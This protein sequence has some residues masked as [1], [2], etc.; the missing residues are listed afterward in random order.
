MTE[1]RPATEAPIVKQQEIALA[2]RPDE[3][4]T[5]ERIIDK[6][7]ELN[8]SGEELGKL[9][10]VY[11]RLQDKLAEK[12][13]NEA[14]A[15]FQAECP[16]IPKSQLQEFATRK[17]GKFKSAYARLDDIDEVV[18]PVLTK[19][20]F[21]RSFGKPTTD[22]QGC[23]SLSATLWHKDGASHTEW[24][25]P[26]PIESGLDLSPQIKVCIALG[27]CRRL[28]FVAACGIRMA[29]VDE[30]VG[31]P[32][33][34][35]TDAQ[36]KELDGIFNQFADPETERASFQRWLKIDTVWDMTQAQYGP[37]KAQLLRRL[38]G[39]RE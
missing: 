2:E 39:Q 35:I 5:I 24:S 21:S 36:F 34:C 8:R 17:G 33:R 19:H 9:L 3:P 15:A 7:V 13:F 32:P 12:R 26:I 29:D 16:A 38:Q 30:A 23:L 37:A 31:E 11:E 22:E 18:M 25:P 1:E 27:F 4:A 14:F 20:G 6:A 10:D 28:A